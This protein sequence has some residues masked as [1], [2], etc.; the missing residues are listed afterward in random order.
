MERIRNMN[1]EERRLEFLKNP[2]IITNKAPKGRYKF[3]QKYY[4]KGAFF[5]VREIHLE[6]FMHVL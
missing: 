3:L 5:M 1:D 4:H 2:K 6:Y